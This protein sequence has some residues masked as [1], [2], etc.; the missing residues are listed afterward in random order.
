MIPVD[1]KNVSLITS[2]CSSV[3]ESGYA[4]LTLD[5]YQDKSMNLTLTFNTI[6]STAPNYYRDATNLSYV[7]NNVIL[8]YDTAN[9][10]F[11]NHKGNAH[12][13]LLLFIVI[14]MLL[15]LLWRFHR[16]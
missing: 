15:Q 14:L 6:N 10:Y 4:T 2:G 7:L 11:Q 9:P 12:N 1:G 8:E 16:N 5:A 3:G 13:L